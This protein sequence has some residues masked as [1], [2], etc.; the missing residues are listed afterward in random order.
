MMKK[1]ILL[2]LH[3]NKESEAEINLYKIEVTSNA[4]GAKYFQISLK[5]KS[6]EY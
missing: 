3:N 1:S 2:L 5:G 4:D 6:K